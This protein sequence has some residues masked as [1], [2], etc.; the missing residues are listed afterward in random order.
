ML[1]NLCCCGD[2]EKNEP[3]ITPV[4]NGSGDEVSGKNETW[5]QATKLL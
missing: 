5:K 2:D 4:M 3:K 1:V